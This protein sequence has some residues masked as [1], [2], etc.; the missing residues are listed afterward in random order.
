MTG[1]S[2]G[3]GRSLIEGYA[4]EGASKIV[5]AARSVDKME[6]ARAR[7]FFA[8]GITTP[9]TTKIHITKADL[10]TKEAS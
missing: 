4:C 7:I 5:M 8:D 10:S 2:V 9:E 3:I 6:L 1:A